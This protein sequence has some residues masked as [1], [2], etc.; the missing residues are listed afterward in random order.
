LVR[1]TLLGALL[2]VLV[3]A[4]AS[5]VLFVWPRAGAP[6]RAD[7]IVSLDGPDE[8]AREHFALSLARRGYAPVL[9]FSQG[10]Y[11]STPCP[12]LAGVTVVCFEPAPA[13]TIGEVEWASVY[14]ARRGWNR[15]LVVA[16]RSQV[17]RARL[18]MH[19]CFRGAVTVVSA[20]MPF[21]M[22]LGQV[23]HEWGG[24]VKAELV[25]RGC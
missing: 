7:A 15:L 18:L 20:P 17:T 5:A 3:F 1:V 10:A 14:A 23:T 11:R 9:L 22:T 24:L 8:G 6:R 25:D 19:R 21:G 4:T 16:G 13:H 2:F 12:T